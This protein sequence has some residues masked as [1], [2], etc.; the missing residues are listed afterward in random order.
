MEQVERCF[1]KYGA[2]PQDINH[3]RE[4][5]G[6][7]QCYLY[8]GRYYRV[9]AAEFDGVPFLVI[10]C[11]DDPRYASVGIM[12]DVNAIPV[13][14]DEARLEREVRRALEIEPYPEDYPDW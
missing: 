5:L 11:I 12:E 2:E 7:R 6:Q 8:D 10:D 1:V 4:K 9:D 14:L 13:S 3:N